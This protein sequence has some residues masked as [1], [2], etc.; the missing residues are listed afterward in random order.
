MIL[1][2]ET[3]FSY[4]F[5]KR[6]FLFARKF[7]Y[8]LFRFLGRPNWGRLQ[9]G[10]KLGI[11]K[12]VMHLLVNPEGELKCTSCQLCVEV[13]PT[14]CLTVEMPKNKSFPYA[15]KSFLFDQFRCITCDYCIAVCPEDA[16]EFSSIGDKVKDGNTEIEKDLIKIR[17]RDLS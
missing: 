16:I 13:C 10:E 5:P 17:A 7:L 14:A 2:R 3:Y 8:V 12:Q 1:D 11:E 4:S 15:P 9:A 6:I